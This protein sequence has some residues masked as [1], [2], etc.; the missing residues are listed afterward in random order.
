[1]KQ[2]ARQKVR[3]VQSSGT[4]TRYSILIAFASARRHKAMMMNQRCC[5]PVIEDIRISC[6]TNGANVVLRRPCSRREHEGQRKEYT[7][8]L[9]TLTML[10]LLVP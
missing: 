3:G 5:L 4:A 1:M 8:L 6:Q 10:P 9:T 2:V 7:N